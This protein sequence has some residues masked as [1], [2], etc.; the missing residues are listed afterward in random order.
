M[1]SDAIQKSKIETAKTIGTHKYIID[2]LEMMVLTLQNIQ[3]RI[4]IRK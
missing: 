3:W 2:C 4:A 1:K